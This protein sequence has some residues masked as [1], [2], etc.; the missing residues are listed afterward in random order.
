MTHTISQEEFDKLTDQILIDYV[1]N[2]TPILWHQMA[3]DWNYDNS[4]TFFNW[5][6]N[7]P[8]TDKA[9]ALMIYWMSAPRWSKKFANREDV[10]KTTSWYIDDFDFIQKLEDKLLNGF[11]RNSNF[12]YNPADEHTG[13][14]WT[15]EY[16]DETTVR[17]IPLVLFDPLEG[18][19][20]PEPA[21]FIEGF[22]PD[23]LDQ[24]DALSDKYEI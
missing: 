18:L 9:T 2:A 8:D 10:L 16:L 6:I 23:I 12:A 1:S 14:N 5:L 17:E 11:F 4:N 22:P 19:I 7:N 24:W 15:K 20:V 3:M 13:T 21:N